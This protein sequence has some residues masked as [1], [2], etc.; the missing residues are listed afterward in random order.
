MAVD[1][2]KTA[3][4]TVMK[5]ERPRAT[6]GSPSVVDVD[7]LA[8][9]VQLATVPA[10]QPAAA[11]DRPVQRRRCDEADRQLAGE[12]RLPDDVEHEPEHVVEQPGDDAAVRTP[13]CTLVGGAKDAPRL[14]LVAV[15]VHVE[16]DAPWARASRERPVVVALH[17]A[18]GIADTALPLLARAD[19]RPVAWFTGLEAR[20]QLLERRGDVVEQ[21]DRRLVADEGVSEIAD[22]PTRAR[23]VLGIIHGRGRRAAC[24]RRAWRT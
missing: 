22:R 10:G 14:D 23:S 4:S 12:R 2:A 18:G 5:V 17:P 16:V 6:T 7:E 1:S 8:L 21:L 9:D 11:G 20:R 15:A 3:G 13:G 19:G 24:S